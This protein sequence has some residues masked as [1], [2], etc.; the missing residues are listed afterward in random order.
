MGSLAVFD[1]E[2]SSF[3]FDPIDTKTTTISGKAAGYNSETLTLL[4]DSTRHE[5]NVDAMGDFE[6]ELTDPLSAGTRVSCVVRSKAG[7]INSVGTTV[8]KKALPGVPELG[9]KEEITD[10]TKTI[11]ILSDEK[12][13]AYVKVGNTYYRTSKCEFNEKTGK[14]LYVIK[15][16]RVKAGRTIGIYMENESGVGKMLRVK[17]QKKAVDETDEDVAATGAGE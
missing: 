17:V 10:L 8:V 2:D 3:T 6:K 1:G 12:A 5:I 13:T 16:E 15:I 7:N 11:K 14:Y 4:I 9:N